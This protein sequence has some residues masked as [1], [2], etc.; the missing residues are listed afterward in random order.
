[1][2]W[3][4]HNVYDLWLLQVMKPINFALLHDAILVRRYCTVMMLF[5][6]L[7]DYYSR[8]VLYSFTRACNNKYFVRRTSTPLHFVS[9]RTMAGTFCNQQRPRF[10]YEITRKSTNPSCSLFCPVSYERT[11]HNVLYSYHSALTLNFES[12]TTMVRSTSYEYSTEVLVTSVLHH[13]IPSPCL[14]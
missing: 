7:Y 8:V 13:L 9:T 1:M 6:A 10:D 12:Y 2:G 4:T 5:L 11:E 14:N 3:T